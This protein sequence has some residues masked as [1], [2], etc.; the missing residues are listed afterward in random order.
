MQIEKNDLVRK[1]P[2]SHSFHSTCIDSWCL[3][4]LNCPVCRSD[5]SR[6][7]IHEKKTEPTHPAYHPMVE[8]PLEDRPGADKVVIEDKYD[9]RESML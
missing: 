1:T 5:L 3:K 9:I 7:G 8:E 2:C 4:N 6:N